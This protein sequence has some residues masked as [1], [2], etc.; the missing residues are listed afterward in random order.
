MRTNS[1]ECNKCYCTLQGESCHRTICEDVS[2]CMN[3]YRLKGECCF[4]CSKLILLLHYDLREMF[5][6][7]FYFASYMY[8]F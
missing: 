6:K 2:D 7:H 1:D 4:V 3:T 8:L 5:L